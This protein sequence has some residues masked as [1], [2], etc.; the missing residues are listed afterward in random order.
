MSN[1]EPCLRWP[2]AFVFCSPISI[3]WQPRSSCFFSSHQYLQ[4]KLHPRR[5]CFFLIPSI[6]KM[7]LHRRCFFL[8]AS[9]F[10]PLYQ[11][12][13]GRS[14]FSTRFFHL[15]MIGCAWFI[16]KGFVWYY[17]LIIHFCSKLDLKLKFEILSSKLRLGGPAWN[18]SRWFGKLEWKIKYN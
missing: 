17:P 9:S 2:D 16:F 4:K 7:K 18:L 8:P 10:S 12:P 1:M 6:S 5:F 14:P 11:E 15:L 13:P 3:K